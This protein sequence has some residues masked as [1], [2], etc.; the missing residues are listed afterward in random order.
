MHYAPD[1][2]I[3]KFLHIFKR[4]KLSSGGDLRVPVSLLFPTAPLSQCATY[5]VQL[6]EHYITPLRLTLLLFLPLPEL[7][8]RRIVSPLAAEQYL[9][10]VNH[11]VR[12]SLVALRSCVAAV[13]C[14]GLVSGFKRGACHRYAGHS[15]SRPGLG[16]D[17]AA[18]RP[19]PSPGR[20]W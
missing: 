13:Q 16:T 5:S 20:G 8:W 3:Y 17:R 9:A 14:P 2:T 11:R 4:E 6:D 7:T 19:L 18:R 1:R 10:R 12:Q 15:P